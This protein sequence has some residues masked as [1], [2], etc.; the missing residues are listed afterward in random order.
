MLGAD[1]FN[2]D[3]YWENRD[4]VVLNDGILAAHGGAWDMPPALEAGWEQ[5]PDLVPFR[6][7]ATDFIERFDLREPWA[8]KDPRSALTFAFWKSLLPDL[9][10]VV[11]VRDPREVVRSLQLRGAT[12]HGLGF[13]LWLFYNQQILEQSSPD[14]RVLTHYESYFSDSAGELRRLLGRLGLPKDES[15]VEQAASL[16]KPGLR[17][18]RAD[19][20]G[21]GIAE[22]PPE[23]ARLY[24][25]LCSEAGFDP[26]LSGGRAGSDDSAGAV[27]WEVL[28]LTADVA[29][30][31]QGRDSLRAEVQR[32][33]DERDAVEKRSQETAEQVARD[34]AHWRSEAEA[35]VDDRDA[36][37]AQADGF[38]ADRD[39]WKAEAERLR[40]DVQHF[41]AL[42]ERRWSRRG[43]RAAHRIAR[44]LWRTLPRAVRDFLRPRLPKALARPTPEASDA[45]GDASASSTQGRA[46]VSRPPAARFPTVP[47]AVSVVIP[48]LNA[49]PEFDRHLAAIREQEG[50][51]A[52]E[53]IV[54]DSGSTDGTCER[55]EAAGA[56]VLQVS[57]DEFSHGGTRNRAVE[58]ASGDVIAMTVQDAIFMGTRTLRDLV[59]ELRADPHMAG[60][61]ARQVPRSDADLYGAFVVWA[62]YRAL[63]PATRATSAARSN[64]TA[65]LERRAAAALDNVC[66]AIRR[67]A[68][69]ELRFSDVSF[70]EDLDFGLR[71]VKRGWRIG[72]SNAATVA[73]SH[74]RDSAYHL[75]RG[76][77]DRLHVAPLVG[78]N[79]LSQV[80]GDGIANAV[81]CAR[82]FL[83][84]VEGAVSVGLG[85]D[86][87]GRL[88]GHLARIQTALDAGSPARH[89]TGE[90]STV[91]EQ[92]VSWQAGTEGPDG[93]AVA[94]RRE[95]HA[96]LGWPPLVEFAD[97]QRAV[98][99]AEAA[100]FAAKLTAAVVG[101]ALGDTLRRRDDPVLSRRF[102]EGV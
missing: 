58:S 96:L 9:K 81:A 38:R 45:K 46:A 39:A 3:G 20:T 70:A 102:L 6:L 37:R 18:H 10:L 54:V 14:D 4:F 78:D 33:A 59:L 50:L 74:R 15:V 41:F 1:E 84:E 57:P 86:A 83:W 36:C 31:Q 90:L 52:L 67:S 72:L 40:G 22:I 28:R 76:I 47:E 11:C 32:F 101:R 5:S 63:W 34:L 53:L 13:R 100:D 91:D 35:I 80:A 27:S 69:E 43:K 62:Y 48:T 60:V 68:W 7:K 98:T 92:L 21:A 29:E 79:A 49:G 88:A 94:L 55:A 73:H 44:R 97:V 25:Q 8:W 17:H 95:F 93:E 87:P 71:A 61:S 12:S 82:R 2:A 65:A 64:G 77:A 89:P 56:S 42:S 51:G 16:P 30:L 24:L 19:Q 23:V 26:S 75:R 99:R 66:A 85:D